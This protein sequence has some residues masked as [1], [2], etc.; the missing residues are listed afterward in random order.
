MIASCLLINEIKRFEGLRKKAYQ[1][2]KG[3]WTIGYGH[4]GED[5]R[6]GYTI[7]KQKAEELL[8]T[9]IAAKVRL[10]H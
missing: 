7:S 1:D 9:H 10:T 5:V 3:V 2:A 4:T 6:E 8:L